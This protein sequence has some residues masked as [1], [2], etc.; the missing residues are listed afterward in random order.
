MKTSSIRIALRRFHE[1]QDG[2]DSVQAVMILAVSAV[3]L[4]AVKNSWPTIR[5]WMNDTMDELL[6]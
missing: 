6:R 2:M 5:D 3:A 4:L 1:E